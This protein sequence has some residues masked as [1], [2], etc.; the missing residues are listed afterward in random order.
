MAP[1]AAARHHRYAPGVDWADALDWKEE[2]LV[3]VA[4]EPLDPRFRL[5]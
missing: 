3:F 4:G 5:S 1:A 2:P